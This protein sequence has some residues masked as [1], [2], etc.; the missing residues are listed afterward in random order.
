[1]AASSREL[2]VAC[3]AQVFWISCILCT[4]G[5]LAAGC[6]KNNGEGSAVGQVWAPECGL[7]GADYSLNPDFFA[8]Q[9]STSV[10]IIDIVVQRGS[11]VKSYSDGISVFIREPELLKETMLGVDI[12][13]GG[14]EPPVEMTFYLNASCPG[15]ARLPVVYGAVSG[16]IRFDELYVPWLSNATKETIAVF[17]NVELVDR[18]DPDERRA[19]LDGNFSFLFERG[20]PHQFFQY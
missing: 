12:P 1:M 10:E 9:P 2:C 4:L 11:D 20:L 6:A 19:V 15:I 18:Q 8:M 7:D 16:T 17:T 5:I 14:L 13:F 3:I